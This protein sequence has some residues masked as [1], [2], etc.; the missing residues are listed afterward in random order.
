M[1]ERVKLLAPFGEDEQLTTIWRDLD[2]ELEDVEEEK[3]TDGASF[4]IQPKNNMSFQED[5]KEF[6]GF[7]D[8]NKQ[9]Q[10]EKDNLIRQIFDSDVGSNFKIEKSKF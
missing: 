1:W 5:F 8:Q 2:V 7:K 6:Q 9:Q 10:M 3:K 4:D